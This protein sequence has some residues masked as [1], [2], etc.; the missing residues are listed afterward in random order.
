[1]TTYRENILTGSVVGPLI[2]DS[3]TDAA[4]AAV[5]VAETD[6]PIYRPI[7]LHDVERL[8]GR[9]VYEPPFF[10]VAS[11]LVPPLAANADASAALG[12]ASGNVTEVVFIPLG[13]VSGP[14]RTLALNGP[15]GV[16][17]SL[18]L[19][20]ALPA[21]EP[22]EIPISAAAVNGALSWSSAH[23]GGGVADPGGLVIVTVNGPV[24]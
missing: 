21:M 11:A 3:P 22:V 12:N 24:R 10:S 19:N 8:L 14:G 20:G 17:A 7:A 23:S 18:G 4:L 13:A 9:S 5:E 2:P 1:M 15:G 16:I 6:Q